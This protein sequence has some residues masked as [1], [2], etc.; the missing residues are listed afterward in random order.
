MSIH[1]LRVLLPLV[2]LAALSSYGCADDDTTTVLSNSAGP[3]PLSSTSAFVSRAV[4]VEPA[5]IEPVPIPGASCPN[6]QPFSAPVSVVFQ[7]Q[8]RSDLSLTQV[9][10]QFVDRTGIRGGVMTI[11]RQDLI[12]SF[13]STALPAF[14]T[15]SFPFSFPF[16]CVG[17]PTG[18]LTVIVF[19]GD[20]L[21][22]G[23]SA[24]V[25][26]DIRERD[27]GFTAGVPSPR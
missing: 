16:G 20:T 13:G 18:T 7:G 5:F 22:R 3:S 23:S 6:Q 2:L 24:T 4:Q 19:A 25:H 12:H 1:H 11:P 14:G 8:G 27:R 17:V 10:M 21:G 9:Q 15:R 26:A